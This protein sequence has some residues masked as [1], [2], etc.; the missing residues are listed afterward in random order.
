MVWTSRCS[1]VTTVQLHG[2]SMAAASDSVNRGLGLTLDGIQWRSITLLHSIAFSGEVSH[3]F[4]FASCFACRLR[5]P[6][7][8]G[9]KRVQ[10]TVPCPEK[11]LHCQS[12]P[13]ALDD[14]C[15]LCPPLVQLCMLCLSPS[16]VA[17][18]F[19]VLTLEDCL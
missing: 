7:K 18:A 11:C 19:V 2:S 8:T 13:N 1:S 16:S 17:R 10:H 4:T 5:R 12:K 15:N 6:G 9:R 14:E 3:C